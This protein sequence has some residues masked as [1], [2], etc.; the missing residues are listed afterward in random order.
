[1]AAT[2]EA[3]SSAGL[4]DAV[5]AWLVQNGMDWQN[6]VH[7]VAVVPTAA[8][9]SEVRIACSARGSAVGSVVVVLE[10][11]AS[12]RVIAWASRMGQWN[13]GRNQYQWGDASLTCGETLLDASADLAAATFE[14]LDRLAGILDERGFHYTDL[15]KLWCHLPEQPLGASR[16]FELFNEARFAW[17]ERRGLLALN[18]W[19]SGGFPSTV[20]VGV[21]S[22]TLQIAFLAGRG[23][24]SVDNPLQVRPACYSSSLASRPALFSRATFLP[25]DPYT[26]CVLVSGTAS[27]RRGAI[28]GATLQQQVAVLR[29]NVATLL[30]V[31]NLR[32]HDVP[33]REA[34]LGALQGVQIY[35][36][37]DGAPGA[38]ASI[39]KS[40]GLR[41]HTAVLVRRSNLS[42]NQLLV[43]LDG[44][45]LV[46]TNAER[47]GTQGG[48]NKGQGANEST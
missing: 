22:K 36:P 19:A 6:L 38:T 33:A 5:T 11:S 32:A 4:T 45:A 15:V 21:P 31:E 25:F 39:A 35:L 42:R 40:L 27:I 29:D 2:L 10:P 14:S 23:G 47:T 1:V 41:Q 26:G 43:E 3:D 17:H 30:S 48:A 12:R 9:E 44:W 18:R 34:G 8:E 20:G 7:A 13:E 46:A 24:R 37:R 28:Q 16:A